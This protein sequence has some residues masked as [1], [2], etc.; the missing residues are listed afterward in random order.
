MFCL[1]TILLLFLFS[2]VLLSK[3]EAQS[4][5]TGMVKPIDCANYTGTNADY[6]TSFS[7]LYRDNYLGTSYYE[8]IGSHPGVDI[9]RLSNG[10]GDSGAPIVAVYDGTVANVLYEEN[11]HGSGWGNCLVIM[12]T[13]IPDA[14]TIYSCY[15]HM[16]RFEGSWSTGQ[17]VKK[18]QVIGYVGTT[19]NSTGPHLHFQLDKDYSDYNHFHPWF[20]TKP[21][22]TD[23]P[24]T[25]GNVLNHTINPLRFVQ[26]HLAGSV[27]STTDIYVSL[28][29]NDVSNGSSGSPFRTIKHA[30]DAASGTQPVTIHIA[31]GSYGEKIG[32]GKHIH[33]VVNGTGA[34]QTGG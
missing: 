33:F 4:G 31:P 11:N 13:N 12:H 2:G 16:V 21:I 19:G 5:F 24:D 25:N 7:T 9:D 10:Q 14:G 30:I 17:N 26:D 28:S 8:G 3:T 27:G 1:K 22:T 18:G 23:T 29:G 32:T 15:G 34:V 20:P 6:S